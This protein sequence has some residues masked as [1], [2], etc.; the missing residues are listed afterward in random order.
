MDQGT[1]ETHLHT[2]YN[3]FAR[4]FVLI[5]QTVV[6]GSSTI[7]PFY[8]LILLPLLECSSNNASCPPD[9]SL[10]TWWTKMGEMDSGRWDKFCCS[11]LCD[12]LICD[13]IYNAGEKMYEQICTSYLRIGLHIF[14]ICIYVYMNTHVRIY[15]LTEIY[16][17]EVN[18]FLLGFWDRG[19]ACGQFWSHF[20][21]QTRRYILK[22]FALLGGSLCNPARPLLSVADTSKLLIA[23]S[24]YHPSKISVYQTQFHWTNLISTRGTF[25]KPSVLTAAFSEAFV[26]FNFPMIDKLVQALCQKSNLSNSTQ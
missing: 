25:W 26:M 24:R 12:L 11:F 19:Q 1:E 18:Y 17:Q 6:P 5:H 10:Q 3:L 7:L 16:K 23:D 8:L 2:V 14:E 4:K 9:C 15:V 13:L 21:H 20:L 22:I